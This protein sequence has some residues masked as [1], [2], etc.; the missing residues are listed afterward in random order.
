MECFKFS[1]NE[2]YFICIYGKEAKIVTNAIIQDSGF[3][4]LCNHHYLMV[5]KVGENKAFFSD[6]VMSWRILTKYQFDQKC[7]LKLPY[8]MAYNFNDQLYNL[9]Y[10]NFPENRTMINIRTFKVIF[11][12][13][14]YR[15]FLIGNYTDWICCNIVSNN[16][17][18]YYSDEDINKK[19][20]YVI[21]NIYNLN[22]KDTEF[23]IKKNKNYEEDESKW[24]TIEY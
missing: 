7:I 3:F 19:L 21:F 6:N 10:Y 2:A 24:K 14:I 13:D 11:D 9:I 17:V 22:I 1:W 18:V 4:S 12:N 20:L 8:I 5:F 16:E 15:I 23:E